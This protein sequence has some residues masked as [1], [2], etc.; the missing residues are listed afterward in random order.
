MAFTTCLSNNIASRYICLKIEI[1][2]EMNHIPLLPNRIR[3]FAYVF[4]GVG[5]ISGYLYFFGGKPAFFVA[6]VFAFVTSYV[7]TRY[8]VNA[9]TNLLDEIAAIFIIGGFSILVFSK[10]KT[11]NSDII[12]L[13][14]K[15]L[16]NAAYFTI[17]VWALVFLF[18]YGWAIFLFSSTV[19]LIFLVSGF[20]IFQVLLFRYKH[21]KNNQ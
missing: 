12:L 8:F 6:K 15:A 14:L 17:I 2:P 7:E 18:I 11:E 19:F 20:L 4:I 16:V 10:E 21:F 1:K 9:Q 3:I 5:I 13:R